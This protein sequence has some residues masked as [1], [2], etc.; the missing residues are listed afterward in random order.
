MQ[1]NKNLPTI[2]LVVPKGHKLDLMRFSKGRKAI[3]LEDDTMPD[4]L[5]LN[6]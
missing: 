1:V 2:I 3:I 6:L 4:S 5:F